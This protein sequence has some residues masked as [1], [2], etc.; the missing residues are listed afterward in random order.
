M[1]PFT[2]DDDHDVVMESHSHWAVGHVAGFS[3]RVYRNDGEIT[4]AF[5]TYHE[6]MEQLAEP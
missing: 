5:T 6:L 1:E 2:D 4:E 3:M